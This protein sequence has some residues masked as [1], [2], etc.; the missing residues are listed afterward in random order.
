MRKDVTAKCVAC[1]G[2]GRGRRH[3]PQ[4][5]AARQAEEGQGEDAGVWECVHS[6]G[7]LYRGAAD[8]GGVSLLDSYRIKGR[9][10]AMELLITSNCVLSFI[11]V[12]GKRKADFVENGLRFAC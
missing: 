12:V 8:G 11:R 5:E 1:P 9:V 4:E 7:G 2:G 3:Q 10:E 6:A